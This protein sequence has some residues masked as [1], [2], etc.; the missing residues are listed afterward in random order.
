MMLLG[1]LIRRLDDAAI[2]TRTLEAL[3]DP[4]LASRAAGAAATAGVDLGEFVSTAARRYLNQA[5]AEE[6]TTLM[7]A[8][9]RASDPGSVLLR[10]SL[11][12]VLAEETC[13]VG[14]ESPRQHAG[15]KS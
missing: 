12:F 13:T 5:P 15:I 11:T 6:W 7:G 9:D 14:S 4:A 2:V 1:D 8:M 10:R 3:G